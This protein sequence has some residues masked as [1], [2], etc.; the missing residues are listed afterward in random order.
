MKG[1]PMHKIEFTKSASEFWATLLEDFDDVAAY[2]RA[3]ADDD[4]VRVSLAELRRK[5]AA[6]E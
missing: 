5:I 4:G 1:M 3:Q 6:K 2:D